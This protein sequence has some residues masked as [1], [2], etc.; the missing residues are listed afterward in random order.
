MKSYQEGKQ[1]YNDLKEGKI[2]QYAH[3]DTRNEIEYYRKGFN[4][5]W[6]K[7]YNACLQNNKIG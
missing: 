4:E 5:G 7:G 6:S 3:K 2:K 1:V